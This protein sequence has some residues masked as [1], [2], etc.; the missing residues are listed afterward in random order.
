MH[1]HMHTY[2]YGCVCLYLSGWLLVALM[3]DCSQLNREMKGALKAVV[4]ERS[5]NS[6]SVDGK[7]KAKRWHSWGRYVCLD[8]L[9]QRGGGRY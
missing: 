5:C 2:I 3:T 6:S 7:S 8:N 1:T 9:V 4:L